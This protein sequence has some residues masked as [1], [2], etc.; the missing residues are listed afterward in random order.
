MKR[1]CPDCKG[2]LRGHASTR[3][4]DCYL[5]GRR[6]RG[7]NWGR[8]RCV[9][10]GRG[11][12][13]SGHGQRCRPCYLKRLADDPGCKQCHG[14]T[15]LAPNGLCGKCAP[16]FTCAGCGGYSKKERQMCR[17]CRRKGRSDYVKAVSPRKNIA[18]G[19]RPFGDE[20]IEELRRRA[21]LRLPL[22]G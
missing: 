1:C 11:L 15:P 12:H 18:C 20:R 17:E 5:K 16:A 13:P 3:C 9:D 10:C 14:H 2:V 19:P 6:G 8:R 21:E 4:R 22:F 7:L